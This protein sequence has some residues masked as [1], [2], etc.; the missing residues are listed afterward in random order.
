MRR[1]EHK[2]LS[3]STT[4]RNP[5]RMASFLR[6]IKDF[7]RQILTEELIK[8]IV[9]KV[10]RD[11][12]YTPMYITRNEELKAIKNDENIT[13]TDS[14]ID[15]II[16]KSPQNHK[17]AGFPKGWPSRFDTWYKLIK[18]FGFLY[19]EMDKPL[20][21]SS[22]GYMLCEAYKS[23]SENSGEKIQ[24]IFCNALMKYQTNN[25]FRRN[26][27]N[28][29]PIPLLLNVLKLLKEDSEEN[30]A[31][32]YR[33]ELPFLSCWPNNDANTLYMYIKQ[34]RRKYRYTASDEIVYE[35]CLEL[36][37]S[38]NRT[39]FKMNQIMVEAVDDLIRKLRI[40]GVF[41]LRGMGRFVD[42]NTL[43]L[44]KV[45]YIINNYSDYEEFSNEHAYFEYM[46]TIDSE[47]VT[48]SSVSTQDLDDVR[49][50]AL[51]QFAKQFDVNYVREEL[52]KLQDN[53]PSRDEYLKLIDS[54]TRLEFLTSI[55][56]VQN[57]PNSIVKPNYSV[58]DEGN[59]TFTAKG[60][61]A[62]IVVED[63]MSDSTIEVTLM[64]N[65]QQA[66]HEIPAITRHLKEL[67]ASGNKGVFSVFVA[68]NIHE[69]TI[70][71]CEFT[72]HRDNLDIYYYNI[73]DFTNKVI[74][75]SLLKE[76][77]FALI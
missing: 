59:P 25:P 46:G 49:S 6:C 65:R 77:E 28:N 56:L 20:E 27:N 70:Y 29:A 17:E 71:M 34:F 61:V 11:K 16:R 41:S 38:D 53:R 4:M 62:D 48:V 32:I 31:G 3:F 58:D 52:I 22:S 5:K 35:S 7:D 13:F 68:P 24:N 19:Y 57:Y 40:T 73:K 10:I 72:K 64:R 51:V 42:I 69:D 74:E 18:E 21:I 67:R 55:F 36:L 39:R 33:K 47:I 37:D 15:E 1:I 23:D 60:G 66:T 44:E 14:Q 76:L 26:A 63:H 30:G 2:P 45:D 54:P 75:T 12:L 9:E 8:R 50:Q 43:Q